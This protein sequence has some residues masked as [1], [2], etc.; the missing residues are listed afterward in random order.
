VTPAFIPDE[1][2]NRI[3]D[4]VPIACVDVA[5]VAR[6]SILLVKRNDAPARGEWWVP[7]GRVWKG[8]MMREAAARKACEEVGMEC[9]VGPIVHTAETIFPDGP[10][11]IAVHSINSCFLLY[12]VSPVS[13][14]RLDEH[15]AEWQWVEAV[16]TGIHPYVEQCLLRAGLDKAD[17]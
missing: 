11:G 9:H 12:P 4:S 17:G 13:E 16:P 7:G 3:L 15:H 1:L 2:Y 5:I 8:E 10:G 6:G 14:P